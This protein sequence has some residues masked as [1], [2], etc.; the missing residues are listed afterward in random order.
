MGIFDYTFR[1]WFKLKTIFDSI[2]SDAGIRYES[3]FLSTNPRFTEM[4]IS[5]A[6][7]GIVVDAEDYRFRVVL[8]DEVITNIGFFLNR[9][10][11]NFTF[12]GGMVP[13]TKL[14]EVNEPASTPPF[15]SGFFTPLAT[16]QHDM[17]LFLTIQSNNIPTATGFLT[18]YPIEIYVFIFDSSNNAF[19]T[20]QTITVPSNIQPTSS[21]VTIRDFEVSF[22]SVNLFAGNDYTIIYQYVIA[23]S[24]SGAFLAANIETISGETYW[25][26]LGPPNASIGLPIEMAQNA[27][28]MGQ[29]DLVRAVINHFNLMIETDPIMPDLVKIEPFNAYYDAGGTVD[30]T[31]K[32]DMSQGVLVKPTTD[33]QAKFNTWKFSDDNDYFSRKRILGQFSFQSD[34]EFAQG[35]QVVQLPYGPPPT[36]TGSPYGITYR[37]ID[38]QDG[39]FSPIG[40]LPR[41]GY[42]RN[43]LKTIIIRNTSTNINTI[44][45]NAVFPHHVYQDNT[46]REL[47]FSSNANLYEEFFDLTFN[48][49]KN[50]GVQAGIETNTINNA[51]TVFWQRYVN[52]IYN[53]EARILE[54]YFALS[55][56]D[57]NTFRFNDK[58]FIKDTFYRVLEIQNYTV[59]E[60]ATT[61][62]ILLSLTG[63][64]LSPFTDCDG[65]PTE[66]NADGTVTFSGSNL[67]ECC[68]R[69][70]Y[71]YVNR[72]CRWR[73]LGGI[74]IDPPNPTVFLTDLNQPIFG[75]CCYR[76]TEGETSCVQLT[77]LQCLQLNGTWLGPNA[78]CSG[79]GV[80]VPSEE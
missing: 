16:G 63:E 21:S 61:K 25:E 8:Q 36:Q 64:A 55:P 60:R 22:Q 14:L 30:W 52:E 46:P 5:G 80:L 38:E 4:Y 77:E 39:A 17:R 1:P 2:F 57:I 26:M 31:N 53:N 43:N 7:N 70:G 65:V 29:L 35:E 49:A 54:A 13:N 59:G 27:P 28:D 32:I 67:E 50:Y 12:T 33:I 62:V 58:V 56:A 78:D 18:T 40:H 72:T 44:I 51:F 20:G 69:Y 73:P 9:H 68:N 15:V 24:P 47:P 66:F 19:V 75:V 6:N 74:Q 42:L 76:P 48:S 41:V 23:A 45:T 3:N 34:N 37:I 10:D 79:C 11:L 71:T